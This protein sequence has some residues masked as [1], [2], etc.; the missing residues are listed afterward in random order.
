M[1]LLP[2]FESELI[3]FRKRLDA[4]EASRPKGVQ[5]GHWKYTL[6]IEV[7]DRWQAAG[8]RDRIW[9][10][11]RLKLRCT[12]AEFIWQILA[13][14]CTAEELARRI[15]GWPKLESKTQARAI[16][17]IKDKAFGHAAVESALAHVF[18]TARSKLSRKGQTA[19]RQ[20]FVKELP[21]ISRTMRTA[22]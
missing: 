14:R 9:K 17:H 11:L 19:A 12:P 5:P 1:A 3:A 10:K 16:R 22:F 21:R 4:L 2:S 8:N 15:E 20:A 7:L 18:I 6:A 13:G